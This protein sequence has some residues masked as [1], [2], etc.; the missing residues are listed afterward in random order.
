MNKD[1]WKERLNTLKDKGKN[2]FTLKIK[3]ILPSAGHRRRIYGAGLAAVLILAVAGVF[4]YYNGHHVFT[5]YVVTASAES[6]DI[7][8]TRYVMLGNSIV[9][10]SSDGVFCVNS[11]NEAKWSTAYSMQ[12]PITNTCRKTM[13]IAEQQGKQVY[14]LNDEGLLGN[15]QTSLPILKADVSAQGVVAL[16]LEDDDVTWI[17]LYD[18]NG[19]EIASVK[20]TLQESGYPLDVAITPN[21]SRMMVS[22]LEIKQG[23]LNSRIAFYDF[24][25]ASESDESHLTGT[26]DYGERVFPEVYYADASTPVAVSDNGFVVFKNSKIPEEKKAV[27]VEKEIVSSFHDE[28]RI[29]FVFENEAEDCR[30]EMELYQYSGKRIMQKEFDCDYTEV[31]MDRGEILLYDAKSCT[32]YTT[33]G[34]RRFTSVYEKPVS[35]F[36]KIPGFRK[37]LVI[38]NDSMDRIRIS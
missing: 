7:A 24:S 8:G 19:G 3:D 12:S 16:I 18:S 9:K 21:A 38:T 13:V 26:L 34:V 6:A 17:N 4:W 25:S 32:I 2:L 29:G 20:T 1:K 10:Y 37:Y 15:F 27:T 28:K 30:Y 33:S 35:Y 14:V 5:E 31:K 11:Q 23:A 36:A 22:Y